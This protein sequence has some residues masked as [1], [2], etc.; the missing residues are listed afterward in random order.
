MSWSSTQERPEREREGK[1]GRKEKVA[2]P[3][4]RVE[5]QTSRLTPESGSQS[6]I[7]RVV[8]NNGTVRTLFALHSHNSTH[9]T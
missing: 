6:H 8:P 1:E 3:L 7:I 4:Y 2:L 9:G 5:S